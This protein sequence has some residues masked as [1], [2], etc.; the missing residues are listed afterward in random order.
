[1]SSNEQESLQEKR[2]RTR[3]S[4]NLDVLVSCGAGEIS[5]Q[6]QNISLKGILCF[7]HPSVKQDEIC[8]VSIWLSEE[9]KIE[10][11]GKVVRSEVDGIAIDFNKM[12]VESFSHLYNL[13]RLNSK[14]PD[15]LD[16]EFQYPAFVR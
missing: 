3:V 13:V 14:D 4:V 9:I 7:P 12:S 1:M 10:L 15:K 5:T 16:K 6:T 2:K 11:Q 8:D